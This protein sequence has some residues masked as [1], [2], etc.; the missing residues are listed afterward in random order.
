M[1]YHVNSEMN[2]NELGQYA[3]PNEIFS[4]VESRLVSD[5][6]YS[7]TL[8][9]LIQEFRHL[10][11]KPTKLQYEYMYRLAESI[12]F[13]I[14]FYEKDEIKRI[15]NEINQMKLNENQLTTVN[16]FI[17]DWILPKSI[18]DKSIVSCSCIN[19]RRNLLAIGDC[20]G[21]IIICRLNNHEIAKEIQVINI[22]K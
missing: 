9:Q 20:Q 18:K 19:Q 17:E 4:N 8:N 13:K 3:K 12:K 21:K 7:D 6:I 11:S 5:K 1:N 16:F 14:N 2:G 15:F 22:T 10:Q